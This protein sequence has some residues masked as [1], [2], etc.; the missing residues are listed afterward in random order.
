MISLLHGNNRIFKKLFNTFINVN[1]A[2]AGV[3]GMHRNTL[4][5]YSETRIVRLT[6][7]LFV[8]LKQILCNLNIKKL[9]RK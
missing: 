1:L 8:Y 6:T 9:Q 7:L 2:Y 3:D 5:Q 4:C